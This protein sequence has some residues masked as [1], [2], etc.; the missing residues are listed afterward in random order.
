[1]QPAPQQ[2]AAAGTAGGRATRDAIEDVWGPRTPHAPAEP[3]PIRGDELV[4]AEPERWVHSVCVLCSTG[5]G[6]DIGVAGGRM[7]GVRGRAVDRVNHGRLGPK[8]L[9]GWMANQSADRLT[10]PLIRRGNDLVEAPWDEAMALVVERFRDAHDSYG[11]GSVGFYNSGQ[12]MLE[13]YYT[14]AVI[15]DAGLGTNNVDGNTRLCTATAA[16]ALIESF[17]TDGAPGSYTDFDLTDALFMVGHNMASTQTVL[18]ARVLDRLTGSNPPSLVVVDPRPT[19]AARRADV[20]LAPRPGTNLAL[21]NGLLRIVIDRGWIDSTFIS[22]HTVGFEELVTTT[23]PWKPERVRDVTGV[24]PAQ[25]M[26]AAEILGTTPTLVSTCLQG[27]YQ[28][29]QATATA[30]QVNNLHLVRGLIGKPG[31]TVFQMNGQPSAQNTRECGANGEFV[32][33]RNWHNAEHVADVARIWN[34]EPSTLPTWTPP[35]DAMRI[36][37][38]CETGAIRALWIMATNPAVSLPE[39]KRIHSILE[40]KDLFVVVSDAWLTETA[41]RADVVLPAAIWG[42]KTGCITNADRTVHLGLKAIEPPGE[43]RSDLD[44]LVD[45]ARRMDFKDKDGQPLVKWSDPE[46]AFDAWRRMS[47]GK[48]CD[49]SGM[50]Y[51]LLQERSSIQWPCNTE[52]PHGRERLYEDGVFN[53]AFETCETFGHDLLTGGAYETDEYAALDPKGRAHIKGAEYVPP[54]EEPDQ[55]YPFFLSTGRVTYH[56]HTRTKTGRAP[57]LQAAAPEPIVEIN[58]A[59]AERLGIAEGDLVEVASRRGRAR[60]V[61]RLTSIEPGLVFMPFHYGDWDEPGRPSTANELT[62]TG[63]DPVSKQPHFKY[64]AVS[65]RRVA[66]GGDTDDSSDGHRELRESENGHS[67]GPS[68]DRASEPAEAR[69]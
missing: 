63:W 16:T 3:W 8:G 36:W 13:E 20:H 45:F 37:R 58:V 38:Y 40:Q 67:R 56:F 27:V 52:Y 35:T 69:R 17:G 47:R 21:M 23:E 66:A 33:F 32:A 57:A 42:E 59:D 53:T 9:H 50:S 65:M 46:S 15:A 2:T 24:E 68:A 64:A 29:L 48:P 28:S 30:V 1:M 12:L 6:L 14:L 55:T 51:A 34:V 60:G 22:G 11:Q 54:P 10:K 41:R 62:L 26:A 19:A 5:C 44:I 43:A 7:V 61:A 39:V 49:Y 25:L 18:W 4:V 31:A